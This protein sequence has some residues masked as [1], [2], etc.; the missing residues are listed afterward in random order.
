MTEQ[1]KV[2]GWSSER[3]QKYHYRCLVL[4]DG[5]LL[6]DMWMGSQRR[7]IQGRGEPGPEAQGRWVRPEGGYGGVSG[8]PC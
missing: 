4:L 2:F 5:R 7:I 3:E 1:T 8:S 6:L